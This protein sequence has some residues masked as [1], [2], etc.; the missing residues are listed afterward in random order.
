[1]RQRTGTSPSTPS[2]QRTTSLQAIGRAG[3]RLIRSVTRTTPPAVSNVVTSTFVPS[4]YCR[5]TRNGTAG[6]RIH[7]PPRPASSSAPKTVSESYL[8]RHSHSI[9]PSSATSAAVCL[10]PIAA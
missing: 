9:D 10:L 3:A 7:D 6:C 4:A 5:C 8:G 2:M 1:M